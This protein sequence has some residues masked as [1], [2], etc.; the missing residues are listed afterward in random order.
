MGRWD[1]LKPEENKDGG[2]SSSSA[3]S[4]TLRQS[5]RANNSSS[6][7]PRS[8]AQIGDSSPSY[9]SW[10]PGKQ[11][12]WN[13][14]ARTPTT[15]GKRI[16]ATQDPTT[17][18]ATSLSNQ[19]HYFRSRSE[20][21]EP[22]EV[23]TTLEEI[24]LSSMAVRESVSLLV[25][26]DLL[27]IDQEIL[28]AAAWNLID[29]RLKDS[30]KVP[31]MEKEEAKGCVEKLARYLGLKTGGH[32]SQSI[33]CLGRLVSSQADQ[34]SAEETAQKVVGPILLPALETL[35]CGDE[36]MQI[37]VFD[38]M[39]KLLSNSQFASAILSP[40]VQDVSTDGK[41]QTVTNPIRKDLFRSL[42][43]LLFSESNSNLLR[44]HACSTLAAT[45]ETLRTTDETSSTAPATPSDLDQPALEQ[46]LWTNLDHTLPLYRPSLLLL[47]AVLRIYPKS[48]TKLA[49]R[50]L[51]P[52]RSKNGSQQDR[53]CP[54]CSCRPIEFSS[55]LTSV[56]NSLGVNALGGLALDCTAELIGVL[57]LDRCLKLQPHGRKPVSGFYRKVVDSLS[58]TVS[59]ARCAALQKQGMAWEESSVGRLCTRLFVA[60]PWDDESLE[61]AGEYLW[62]TLATSFQDPQTPP[63]SHGAIAAALIS[64][65]GGCVT[66]QGDLPPMVLPARRW[67]SRDKSGV[68]FVQSILSDIR[69]TD[70]SAE[71]SHSLDLLC[72]M[73]RT[74]PETVLPLWGDFEN[75]I[76]DLSQGDSKERGYCL[77][78]MEAF[79]LGRKDFPSDQMN[80]LEEAHT[81]SELAFSLLESAKDDSNAKNRCRALN[82]YAALVQADWE[83]LGLVD[84]GRL[85]TQV[86]VLLQFCTDPK[87]DVRRAACKA[88]GEF[89]SEYLTGETLSG[90]WQKTITETIVHQICETMSKLV[91]EDTN[92]G[93]RS[94]V[95]KRKQLQNEFQ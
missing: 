5:Q 70:K 84:D 55:F 12:G 45:I 30:S 57:P 89:S 13:V 94:M 53:Q 25:L 7:N 88:V 37:C 2:R 80:G 91:K 92:A 4:P 40:L 35:P 34:L 71:S 72:A 67:L 62:S 83:Y 41:T 51:F 1:A 74:R 47:R 87:A 27:E 69:S 14:A 79:L 65:M 77:C 19:V 10:K 20:L 9:Q 64:S 28:Q 43:T 38:S 11:K 32:S 90:P 48:V 63:S 17:C 39:N 60:I 85:M 76:R 24:R 50:L 42:Q 18:W 73:L 61:K 93:A 44:A 6:A 54:R 21:F 33:R 86:E 56:H 31:A 75:L 15:P 3:K 52:D 78:I 22:T 8:N 59:I 66:P 36:F 16:L 49:S 23:Q 26:V 46:F 68:P 82:S 29:E 95:R 58:Q 81:T